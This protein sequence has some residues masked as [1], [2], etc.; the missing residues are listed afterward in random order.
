VWS[1]NLVI[2]AEVVSLAYDVIGEPSLP[3]A[4][5]V[6]GIAD[7]R[8]FWGPIV[9]L[10]SVN[11]QIINVD[12]RGHGQS[13]LASAYSPPAIASADI[14]KVVMANA[15]KDKLPP[16]MIGHSMGSVLV[17][18]Y[19]KYYPVRGVVNIDQSL[20]LGSLQKQVLGF[21]EGLR[22][23]TFLQVINGMFSSSYGNLQASEVERLITSRKP[24]KSAVLGMWAPLLELSPSELSLMVDQ[25]LCLPEGVNYL[26]IHGT[27]P[28]DY[29]AGWL[30]KRIP[31]SKVE[32]MEGAST[33]YPHLLY[34]EKFVQRVLTFDTT[35]RN[36]TY[37]MVQNKDKVLS[38]A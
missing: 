14:F 27:T 7:D 6:H 30:K 16:L 28:G 9:N 8:R 5:L 38:K 18:T 1:N 24:A 23:S 13:P 36:I 32:R 10:L 25:S 2:E 15:N 19:A 26:S 31:L 20:D 22:G 17:T 37:V 12:M 3:L 29:Y 11:Y 35:R 21:A 33:H 34:P 4:V